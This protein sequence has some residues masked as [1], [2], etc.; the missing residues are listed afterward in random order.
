MTQTAHA[1]EL[2]PVVQS[3]TETIEPVLFG[4]PRLRR[5]FRHHSEK[6]LMIK[7]GGNMTG[8]LKMQLRKGFANETH[9]FAS[10]RSLRVFCE[11]EGSPLAGDADV[12]DVLAILAANS[13][14][15]LHR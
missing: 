1:P 5:N 2:T 11:V 13:G 15:N 7:G 8:E 10:Y 14:R 3:V 12:R 4:L 6:G 9:V